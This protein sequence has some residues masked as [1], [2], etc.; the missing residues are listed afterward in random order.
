[1]TFKG[2]FQPTPFDDSKIP[3]SGATLV[4]VVDESLWPAEM[5]A[6]AHI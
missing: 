6:D 1:M 5:T 2:N 3:C 4:D